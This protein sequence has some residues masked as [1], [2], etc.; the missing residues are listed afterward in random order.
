MDEEQAR[1]KAKERVA[2]LKGF[3]RHLAVYSIVNTILLVINLVNSPNHLWFYWPLLGWGIGIM[4]HGFKVFNLTSSL[5]KTW[6]D[7]KIKEL[8]NKYQ[9]ED[10]TD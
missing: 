9:Q 8:T 5:F 1:K 4:S 3:Y 6:E 2:E 10:E 7:K